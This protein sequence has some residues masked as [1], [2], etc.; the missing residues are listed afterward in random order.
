MDRQSRPKGNITVKI[1]G[2]TE[3]TREMIKIYDWQDA[4][5]EMSATKDYQNERNRS[6]SWK[7]PA[8]YKLS[9]KKRPSHFR[10]RALLTTGRKEPL[11]GWIIAIFSAIIVGVLLGLLLLH[12][13]VQGNEEQA[14]EEAETATHVSVQGEQILLPATEFVFLQQGVYENKASFEKMLHQNEE[15]LT[16][17]EVEGRYH[18]FAGVAPSLD[19][20]KSMREIAFYEE[21]FPKALTTKEKVLSSISASE[22]QFLETSLSFYQ[23]L[24]EAGTFL[25]LESENTEVDLAEIENRYQ[26]LTG[27]D[28]EAKQLLELKTSLELAYESL[29]NFVETKTDE[30]WYKM[31]SHLL[32]F[33]TD[34]YN[35]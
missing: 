12:V 19:V 13:M 10:K 29:K 35:L 21:M 25:F 27:Y 1:N 8:Y 2:K 24:L 11:S 15:P 28:V 33:A 4:R 32:A 16:F 30:E 5:K 20:A 22:K 7:K 17:I 26:E 18:V 3:E 23:H 34:Y 14:R 31:Q 9:H 6:V